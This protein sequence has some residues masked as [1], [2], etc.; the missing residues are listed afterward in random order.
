MNTFAYEEWRYGMD[1][2]AAEDVFVKAHQ[3][4][5]FPYTALRLPMVNAA[6]DP[7]KRLYNYILRIR[8]GGP[9]LVPETPNYALRHVFA[10]DVIATILTL[11]DTGKGKGEAYNICQDEAVSIDEFVGLLGELMG[12]PTSIV[13]FKR[14][15][16]EANGFLPDCSPFSERWMSELSNERS[17]AELG[18]SY[19]PLRD[20]LAQLIA[21]Y[22]KNKP[23]IPV[24]Y[25][26]RSAELHMA[27]LAE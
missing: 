26:R 20:Y 12:L 15:E 10:D 4:M 27:K 23:S 8:D 18:I 17:K 2:R 19:T 1:K 24:G 22:E 21:H 3:E 14:S 6:R 5:G 7:F 13:R 11:I 16:L 9:I 25:K